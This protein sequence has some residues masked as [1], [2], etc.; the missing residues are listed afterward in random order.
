[1]KKGCQLTDFRSSIYKEQTSRQNE[2]GKKDGTGETR[3]IHSA[4]R[5]PIFI[6]SASKDSFGTAA[7]FLALERML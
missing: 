3:A 7:L 2:M 4:D 5:V 6:T 1:M